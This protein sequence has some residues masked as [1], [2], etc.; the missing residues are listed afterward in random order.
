MRLLITT[1]IMDRKDPTLGFFVPW[2]EELSKR[3]ESVEVICLQKGEFSLP[4]NV[5]VRSLGKESMRLPRPLARIVYAWRFYSHLL[6]LRP[7]DSVFVHMNEEHLLLG[8]PIWTLLGKKIYFWRNHY[9]GS[10]LVDLVASYATKIFCTSR[11]SYTAKYRNTVF[12]PIGVNVESLAME[13]PIERVP[14]SILSLARLSPS[15]RPEF[16]LEAYA[17]LKEKGVSFTASFVGGVKDDKDG[18]EEELKELA[19][20]L[21][22]S[23]RVTFVGAVPNT[24]TF[25]HYRAAEI[26]VNASRSGMLDKAMFKAMAAGALI[27]ASS[28]DLAA[29]VP[30]DFIFEEGNMD[31]FVRK[32]E[33]LL[34]FTE[35]ERIAARKEFEGVVSRHSLPVLA[36][37]LVA[38]MSG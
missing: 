14:R 16:L 25:R 8:G 24:E 32:L 27:L 6:T 13:I 1:Q 30:T 28:K 7:Y 23:D 12:M 37:R 29:E 17:R 31:D 35:E 22:V 33:R 38:E 26:F 10:P 5:R 19:R 3:V 9:D 11:Y 36:D 20:T 2:V 4:E 15:K 18:Y 34:G 21:N